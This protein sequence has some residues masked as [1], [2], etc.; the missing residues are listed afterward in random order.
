MLLIQNYIVKYFTVPTYSD[1]HF[2]EDPNTKILYPSE[3]EI[4]ANAL[5]EARRLIGGVK[6]EKIK[7]MDF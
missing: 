2:C 6:I 4:R 5:V 1:T 3:Y 7:A